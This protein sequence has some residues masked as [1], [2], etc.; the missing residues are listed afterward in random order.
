MLYLLTF[1]VC[2]SSFDLGCRALRR[3]KKNP[4][5]ETHAARTQHAEHAPCTP[6]TGMPDS[7][8][9]PTLASATSLQPGSAPSLSALRA[10]RGKKWGRAACSR[11]GTP[12]NEAKGRMGTGNR[13]RALTAKQEITL[14][15]QLKRYYKLKDRFDI[16]KEH[17]GCEPTMEQFA[18][19]LGTADVGRIS[20][21]MIS[22]PDVKA[23]FVKHNMGLVV[24]IC[25]KY[26]SDEVPMQVSH[27]VL[28][29]FLVC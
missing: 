1:E 17:L 3:E 28:C 21:L 5:A 19:Q 29:L 13:V 11:V 14:A 12:G 15:M 6:S 9:V 26:S 10:G 23:A 25:Q 24:S 20:E 2:L 8:L 22:G 18:E 4:V 16:L 7:K 27:S